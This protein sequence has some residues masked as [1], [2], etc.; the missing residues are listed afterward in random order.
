MITTSGAGHPALPPTVA[1]PLSE[2]AGQLIDYGVRL[3]AVGR[4]GNHLPIH[5]SCLL[6]TP[7]LSAVLTAGELRVARMAA[8][9]ATNSE[10]AVW[11][12]ISPK[13]VETHL[14]R[15]YRKASVRSRTELAYLLTTEAASA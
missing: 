14:T 2:L 5:A 10:I 15:T 3:Y 13:T 8:A 9:G 1:G 11:L 12:Q 6:R 7:R 4:N